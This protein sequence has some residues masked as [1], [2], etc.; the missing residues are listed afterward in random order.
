MRM[1][2]HDCRSRRWSEAVRVLV[3]ALV[4]ASAV[5]VAD[6]VPRR[7]ILEKG[8]SYYP[9]KALRLG[10]EGRVVV[11][12]DIGA[13]GRARNA[14]VVSSEEPA[15]DAAALAVLANRRFDTT[16]AT[17]GRPYRMGVAFCLRPSSQPVSFDAGVEQVI[18]SGSRIPGGPVKNPWTEG[19][20]KACS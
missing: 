5:A 12:F 9:A 6:E 2:N 20:S 4:F 19:A 15:L 17:E 18:I 7:Q 13:D 3:G 11:A 1:T 14:A 10:Q 8:Q 16:T